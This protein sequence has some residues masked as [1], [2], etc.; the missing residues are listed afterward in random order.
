MSS[1]KAASAARRAAHPAAKRVPAQPAAKPASK[2]A[3]GAAGSAEAKRLAAELE[4][5]LASGRRDVLS[6]DA[7]QALMAAVCKTYAAQIEAGEQLLPLPAR[8]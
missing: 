8:G 6:T 7:L 1:P 2:I 4:R 5:A 3:N